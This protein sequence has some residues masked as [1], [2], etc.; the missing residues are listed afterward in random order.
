[1]TE[2]PVCLHATIVPS[3]VAIPLVIVGGESETPGVVGET[4]A[5]G[6]GISLSR[7]TL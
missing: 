2:G 6:I 3:P 4:T 5:G 1:M 7:A